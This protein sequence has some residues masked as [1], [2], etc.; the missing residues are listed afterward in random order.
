MSR[1]VRLLIAEDD[2]R[3][4]DMLARRLRRKGFDVVVAFD[5][6][7]AVEVALETEPDL[8]LMDLSMPRVDGWEAVKWVRKNAR[9]AHV[10]VI[11]ITAYQIEGI[12]AAVLNAGFDDFECKPLDLPRLLEKIRARVGQ[13]ASTSP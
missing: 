1:G 7:S 4:R 2:D 5:G 3:S 9:I 13:R 12:G 11:A 10:P 8:I 6:I